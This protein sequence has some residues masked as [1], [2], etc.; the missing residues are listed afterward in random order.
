LAAEV[1][2]IDLSQPLGDN[3]FGEIEHAYNEHGVI[4][5]PQSAHHA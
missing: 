4:F 3:L 1:R 5:F 2:G